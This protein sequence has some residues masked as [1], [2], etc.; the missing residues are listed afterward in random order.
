MPQVAQQDYLRIV[1]AKGRGGIAQDAAAFVRMKQSLHR[2]T[3]LDVAITTAFKEDTEDSGYIGHIIGYYGDT[4]VFVYDGLNNEIVTL[5][6]PYSEAQYEGLSAVQLAEDAYFGGTMVSMP[7]LGLADDEYL[8]ESEQG[9]L[10]CIDDYKLIAT[11]NSGN[12]AAL[13][14]SDQKAAPDNDD[15]INISWED[16]QKLIGLPIQ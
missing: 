13:S 2:G 11:K 6:L 3:I 9:T 14:I 4:S 12:L 7:K 16:A 10:I 15:F 1:P 8:S 5:L